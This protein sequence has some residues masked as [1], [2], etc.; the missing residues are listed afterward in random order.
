MENL[1]NAVID[2]AD[3]LNLRRFSAL[4]HHGGALVVSSVGV[5][6]PERVEKIIISGN[7]G[8]ATR[9]RTE[10]DVARLR[11]MAQR[12]FEPDE[13]GDEIIRVWKNIVRQRSPGSDV[14]DVVPTFIDS[15]E[16]R[17]RPY[18]ILEVYFFWNRMTA[19]ENLHMPVLLI[20]AE[21]DVTVRN[22]EQ[23]RDRM[24]NA[25]IVKLPNCGVFM[26]YDC[27]EDCAK[28]VKDFLT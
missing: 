13:A 8:P 1:T 20:Q 18:E 11:R 26:F 24:P 7:G 6:I 12:T 3:H 5:T 23:L 28:V 17:M 10:E 9:E 14:R 27:P 16:T 4:G 22:V 2:L 15:I 25:T 21:H 19:Q